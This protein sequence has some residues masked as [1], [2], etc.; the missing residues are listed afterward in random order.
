MKILD[1]IFNNLGLSQSYIFFG[2]DIE[3]INKF[4]LEFAY[5]VIGSKTNIMDSIIFL[6]N[7]NK[8]V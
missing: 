3:L 4:S 7:V 6:G 5:R 1:E 8:L 2:D